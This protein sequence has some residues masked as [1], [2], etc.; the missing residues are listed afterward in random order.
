[1]GKHVRESGAGKCGRTGS[2]H[3]S[4]DNLASALALLASY[5][6]SSGGVRLSAVADRG[7]RARVL[8]AAQQLYGNAAVQRMIADSSAAAVQRAPIYHDTRA[9]LTWKDFQA[10]VDPTSTFDAQT[11]SGRTGLGV[12][13]RAKKVKGGWEAEATIN[14]SSL[15]LRAMMNPARSW[16][17]KS[18][19]GAGLL[20]HE[21]GHFDI[22][23]V[24]VEKSEV[25][26]RAEAKGAVGTGTA[27]KMKAAGNAAIAN[28]KNTAPFT[29]LAAADAVIAR[30]QHEYDEHPTRGTN[31]GL[32]AKQQAQWAAD[33]AKNLPAY[34]IS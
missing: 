29:K 14:A 2:K 21:Q 19:R 27:K 24:L 32:K 23:H 17:K 10:K 28:L 4:S 30:A 6:G 26:V 9:A 3:P 31:H 18:K 1:M 33:I 8:G 34:S 12:S 20:A 22:Q 7:S 16:S 11:F 5:A 15:N 13:W 25:A